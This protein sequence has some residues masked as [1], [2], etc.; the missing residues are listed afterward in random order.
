V[1][2]GSFFF[3]AYPSII[4]ELAD[5]L[6][7]VL[8]GLSYLGTC[9]AAELQGKRVVPDHCLL[10][11]KRPA[12]EETDGDFVIVVK[13][14][15]I[16]GVGGAKKKVGVDS[17]GEETSENSGG[18]LSASAARGGSAERS[19]DSRRKADSRL[20]SAER[21]RVLLLWFLLPFCALNFIWSLIYSLSTALPSVTTWTYGNEIKAACYLLFQVNFGLCVAVAVLLV[22][23]HSW[24]SS[25]GRNRNSIFVRNWAAIL[26]FL[27][28]RSAFWEIE[29]QNL[30]SRRCQ[31]DFTQVRYH[32]HAIWHFFSAL[33]H[34]LWVDNARDLAME[35]FFEGGETQTPLL[36][37]KSSKKE[38]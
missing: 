33:S 14:P 15:K 4:T 2:F 38:E 22:A 10:G 37:R 23:R 25:S 18:D 31:P 26:V 13:P 24:P 21:D 20:I 9:Y 6:P 27:V 36:S 19:Q 30:R 11:L 34:R 12:D 17:E 16:E 1:G 3:H 32:F 5:E 35:D 7:M 28:G 29:Q 8:L